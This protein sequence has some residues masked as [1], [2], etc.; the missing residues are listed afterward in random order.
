MVTG[1]QTCALR[2]D[3]VGATGSVVASDHGDDPGRIE[4][5]ATATDRFGLT[6]VST[7]KIEPR[8]VA[9]TIT[10]TP[11][12]AGFVLD[13]EQFTTP[14][15]VQSIVGGHHV[16]LA[17]PRLGDQIF[18]SW[19]VNGV[20]SNAPSLTFQ[21]SAAPAAFA[22]DYAPEIVPPPAT[23][24]AEPAPPEP[25][26]AGVATSLAGTVVAQ[27]VA[28][29]LSG[30]ATRTVRSVRVSLISTRR[31]RLTIAVGR[32]GRRLYTCRALV[33]RV[34]QRTKCEVATATKGRS[35]TVTAV[36]RDLKRQRFELRVPVSR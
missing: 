15:V 12:G 16:L 24:P 32:D 11:P 27:P 14:Q 3:V 25:A 17:A 28:S 23:P 13:G 2:S 30:R 35:F 36:L 18:R 5:T 31:G 10:S 34:G 7:V 6:A 9:V 26:L 8:R 33:G 4:I 19:S 29:P 1:V 21:T 20:Q 22:I